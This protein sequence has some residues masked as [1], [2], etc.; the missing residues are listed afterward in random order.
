MKTYLLTGGEVLFRCF[1]A[2]LF[3]Y[4]ASKELERGGIPE[5]ILLQGYG[6]MVIGWV[7][8][9]IVNLFKKGEEDEFGIR[10]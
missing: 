6:I 1:T 10:T 3:L 7:I 4:V 9:P 5:S 8:L 2:I